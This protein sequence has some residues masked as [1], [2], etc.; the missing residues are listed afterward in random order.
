MD[1]TAFEEEKARKAAALERARAA[2]G[3]DRARKAFEEEKERKAAALERARKAGDSNGYGGKTWMGCQSSVHGSM[4][5]FLGPQ[6]GP[7]CI[8][9][10]APTD[11]GLS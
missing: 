11:S 1:N 3:V 4:Y 6:V 9:Q 8:L 10:G 5:H 2:S 7:R